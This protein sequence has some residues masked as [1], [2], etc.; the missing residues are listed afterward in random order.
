VICKVPPSPELAELLLVP[1]EL[2]VDEPEEE[3][4]LDPDDGAVVVLLVAELPLECELEPG[5]AEPAFEAH[6]VKTT[7]AQ[8]RHTLL[9]R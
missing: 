5:P 2:F 8:R 6:P 9:I 3:E 1:E 4:E 7:S